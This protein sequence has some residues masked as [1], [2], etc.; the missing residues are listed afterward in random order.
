MIWLH[1]VL[2]L[3]QIRTIKFWHIP[4]TYKHAMWKSQ[5]S[6]MISAFFFSF[7]RDMKIMC[8]CV[9]SHKHLQHEYCRCHTCRVFHVMRINRP[10]QCLKNSL[11]P[12]TTIDTRLSHLF[13]ISFYAFLMKQRSPSYAFIKIV[14]KLLKL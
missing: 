10:E 9:L 6:K 3:S 1:F 13:S 4:Y 11:V 12:L 14:N 8:R 7:N 2:H 5:C